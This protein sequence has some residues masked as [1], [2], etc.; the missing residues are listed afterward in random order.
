MIKDY[1]VVR[2]IQDL[3]LMYADNT[4]ALVTQYADGWNRCLETVLAIMEDM[5]NVE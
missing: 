1:D 5:F 2:L 3:H 4:D